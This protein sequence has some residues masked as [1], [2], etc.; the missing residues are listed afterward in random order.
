MA[1]KESK[2][3]YLL[4]FGIFKSMIETLIGIKIKTIHTDGKRENIFGTFVAYYE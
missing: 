4:Y 2:T 1:S 3:K